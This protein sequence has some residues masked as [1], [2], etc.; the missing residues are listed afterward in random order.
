MLYIDRLT[1]AKNGRISPSDILL[2]KS[3]LAEVLLSLDAFIL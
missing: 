2:R 3:I 1:F